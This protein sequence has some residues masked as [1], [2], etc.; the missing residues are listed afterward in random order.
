[1]SGSIVVSA[2][3]IACHAD[4]RVLVGTADEFVSR[5]KRTETRA[6]VWHWTGGTGN[7]DRVLRTLR[8]RRLS[9]NFI[10][11]RGGVIWQCCDADRATAHA[12]GRMATLSAN[13]WSV[14]VE[15]C[16]L[17]GDGVW[18]TPHQ[19]S[20]GRALA[21]A[22]SVAYGLPMWHPESAERLS[23]DEL[24]TV[25]GHIGHHHVARNKR[26]PGQGWLEAT[27]YMGWGS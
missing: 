16:G 9:I 21:V 25:R 7:H 1:M 23:Q 3:P 22:L 4:V 2:R 15:V 19:E 12:G 17:G 11:D 24:S 5:P 27:C 8:N 18:W 6:V 26:D 13:P 20:S 14:G 10:I